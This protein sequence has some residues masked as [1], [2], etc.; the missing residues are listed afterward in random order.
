MNLLF[1]RLTP[2]AKLPTK[3][4]SSDIGFDL[5]ADFDMTLYPLEPMKISTGIS[6]GFPPGYAGLILDRSS[7]GAKGIKVMGG[8]IDQAYTGDLIVC[9]VYMDRDPHKI[10]KIAKGDK[11]AQLVLIPSYEVSIIEVAQLGD[12]ERGEKGFGSS[13]Q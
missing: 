12:T 1:K 11:I 6:C 4:H 5:Y 10:I 2:S 7:M 9:L 13:G 8:V 3:A